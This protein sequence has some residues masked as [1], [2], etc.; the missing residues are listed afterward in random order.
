MTKLSKKLF[1]II[2]GLLVLVIFSL[3]M[4]HQL[5]HGDFPAHIQWAR[6]YSE[7]GYLYKIPHTLFARLVTIVRALLPANIL[8]WV[9]PMAKQIYDLKSFDISALIVMVLSYLFT[10]I[11]IVVR[12]VRE[13]EVSEKQILYLVGFVVLAVLLAAPIFIFTFPNRMFSGYFVGNRYDSPTYILSKPFV[14]LMFIGIVDWFFEKWNWKQ[15]IIM[16]FI[17]LCATLAKP[18]FTITILPAI[19]ILILFNIKQFKKI[20]WAYLI[21]PLALTAFIVLLGQFIIN[22]SGDRGDRIIFAPFQDI[23]YS[24]PNIPMVF[25]LILMSIVFPLLVTILNW[26]KVK[27][28]FSF[29]LGWVNLIIGFVYSILLG[30]QINMGLNNFWNSPDIGIF[31]LFFVTIAWWGKD[32]VNSYRAKTKISKKQVAT[33]CILLLHFLCGIVYYIAIMINTSVNVG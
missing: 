31:V 16:A 21:I 19:G 17:V 10:A 6:E 13:W 15:A 1:F 23:L 30:E 8:V 11:F 3:V 32:L 22:Y 9:S 29:Q 2:L 26:E 33:T 25:F 7:N 18:S 4:F 20:N 14:L 5:K 12:L 24:V 28:N 27:R